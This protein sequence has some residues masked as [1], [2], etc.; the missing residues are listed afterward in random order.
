MP[1]MGGALKGAREFGNQFHR[2]GPGRPRHPRGE[3][4]FTDVADKLTAAA[5]DM[6]AQQKSGGGAPSDADA[7]EVVVKPVL[8]AAAY[9]PSTSFFDNLKS[10]GG[11]GR[12]FD[13]R[14]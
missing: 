8:A 14:K 3:F 11:S 6:F 5:S 9:N 13:E 10:T 7:G 1:G 2:G 12:H 4:D